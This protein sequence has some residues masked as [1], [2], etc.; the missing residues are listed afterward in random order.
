MKFDAHIEALYQE[1]PWKQR[2]SAAKTDGFSYIEIWDWDNKNLDE[3]VQLC[4]ENSLK[5]AAISGDKQ[6]DMCNPADDAT[7]IA[8]VIESI[9]VAAKIGAINVVIHSNELTPA[10]PVKNEYT[11]LSDTV[12]LCS[13]FHK[14]RAL[15]PY[16]EKNNI[17]LVV[18]PLNIITDH[19]GNFLTNTQQ[20]AELIQAIGSP[21]IKILYDIYHMYLNEGKIC[22]TLTKYIS[23]IGHIHFADAPGRHEPNTGVIN[24]TNIFKYL[25]K[26]GY[27]GTI[28]CELFA[29]HDTKEAINQIKKVAG[30]L[31]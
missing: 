19:I 27:T 23:D 26:L 16:A 30:N 29:L 31:F 14:L 3:L 11:N 25:D 13:M 22:E 15:A 24:Y 9:E 28:G 17:T 12:K 6:F 21:N 7:Y 20:T 5:I 2:F 18:E 8:Q 4:S 10:G 1:L